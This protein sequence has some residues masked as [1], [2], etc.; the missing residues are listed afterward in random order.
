MKG[1]KDLSIKNKLVAIILSVTFFS[2][3]LGAA[4]L[5]VNHIRTLRAEL[6]NNATINARLVGEYCIVPLT[7]EDADELSNILANLQTI[8]S[9][10][11]A[12]VH[13]SK[14]VLL[15]SYGDKGDIPVPETIDALDY[16]RFKGSTL[17]VYH[18]IIYNK[19]KSKKEGVF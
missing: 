17:M 8:P 5:I 7:F 16:N 2:I 14:G 4:L 1:I 15:S 12:Y 13:D 3:T 10:E 18:V 6:V 9:I 11:N 19:E